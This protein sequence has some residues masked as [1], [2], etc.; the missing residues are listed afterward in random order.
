M[1]VYFVHLLYSIEIIFERLIKPKIFARIFVMQRM[2]DEC[3]Y[4]NM[5][6]YILN[7]ILFWFDDYF[8]EAQASFNISIYFYTNVMY[9]TSESLDNKNLFYS[10][11]HENYFF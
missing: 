1:K 3:L 11:K 4:T 2:K 7:Y 9:R 6:G 5:Y 10:M 8:I